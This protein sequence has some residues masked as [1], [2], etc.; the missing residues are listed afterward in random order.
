ML[1]TAGIVENSLISGVATEVAIVS[2]EA[3]GS[4]AE[5]EIVGKSTRGNAATG[6][7]R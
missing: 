1:W 5:T 6:S 3:P 7:V 4:C 2:G